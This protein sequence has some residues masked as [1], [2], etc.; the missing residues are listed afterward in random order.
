MEINGLGSLDQISNLYISKTEHD[1]LLL[2]IGGNII[3][4]LIRYI[5]PKTQ[6]K[7]EHNQL[8]KVNR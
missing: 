5:E 2:A 6:H 3:T 7:L 4:Q 8:Q 1:P